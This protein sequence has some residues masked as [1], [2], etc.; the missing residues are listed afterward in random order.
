ML[1]SVVGRMSPVHTGAPECTCIRSYGTSRSMMSWETAPGVVVSDAQAPAQQR[2][3][4]VI[5]VGHPWAAR[6]PKRVISR[7]V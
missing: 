6:P 4:F 2:S 3:P 1:P 5:R 7:S